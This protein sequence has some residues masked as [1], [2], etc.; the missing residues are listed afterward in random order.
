[1]KVGKSSVWRTLAAH[2]GMEDAKDVR[3]IDPKAFTAKEMYGHMDPSK[4]AITL[5]QVSIFLEAM[6]ILNPDRR[7][8]VMVCFRRLC[9]SYVRIHTHWM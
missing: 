8:G 7:S 4:V 6:I 3:V 2:L 9:G 1:M 5:R